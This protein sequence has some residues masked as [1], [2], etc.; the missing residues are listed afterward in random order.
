MG[1]LLRC[2]QGGDVLACLEA[3]VDGLI[4]LRQPLS[5]AS[6]REEFGFLSKGFSWK[7]MMWKDALVR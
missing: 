2:Q 1:P 4:F 7:E 6:D 3:K 5:N